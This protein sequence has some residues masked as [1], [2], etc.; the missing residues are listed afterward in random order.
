MLVGSQSAHKWPSG[1]QI[2]FKANQ[3]NVITKLARKVDK[4]TFV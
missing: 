2:K 3:K 1:M 4:L